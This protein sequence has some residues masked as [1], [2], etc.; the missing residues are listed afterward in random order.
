MEI[1]TITINGLEIAYRE[2]AGRGPAAIL[3]HGN[4]ASSQAFLPQ[5]ESPLGERYRLVALDLPGHGRSSQAQD[6]AATYTLP[7]YAGVLRRF[8][9]RLG[10]AEAVLVGWS[11]GGHIVLEASPEFPDAAG[12][13][14]FGTPPLAMPPAMEAAFLPHPAMGASFT[15]ELTDEAIHAYATAFFRPGAQVPSPAFAE[16]IRR[17]DGRARATLGASISTLEARD[18]VAL[19]GALTTPLAIVHGSEEQL[20]N[21]AYLETVTAPTLWRGGV[22]YIP[23][24]GHAPHWEQPEQF[25]NLLA[26]FIDDC[27]GRRSPA[28]S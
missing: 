18:E 16:D 21:G 6:P 20:V 4:S 28:D 12:L 1:Q 7:G 27:A 22:Q 2:S 8:A 3:V 9:E 10:L 26:A 25:N 13:F 23:D 11:L 15:P 5:L 19:V 14:V 24:A 17:T